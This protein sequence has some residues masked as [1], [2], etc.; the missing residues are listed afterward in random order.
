MGTREDALGWGSGQRGRDT[1]TDFVAGASAGSIYKSSND[2]GG[3]EPTGNREPLL[4]TKVLNENI[5]LRAG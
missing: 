5:A 1:E 2:P 3:Y 4:F